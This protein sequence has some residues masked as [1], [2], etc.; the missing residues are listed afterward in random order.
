VE[1]YSN[2]QLMSQTRG[3]GT[4]QAATWTYT[5]DPVTLGVA[6]ITDPNGHSQHFTYDSAG[7]TL[8]DSDGLNHQQTFTY[9]TL[10]DLRTFTDRNNNTTIYS[11]NTRGNLT[12]ISRTLGSQTQTT[13]FD[14]ADPTYPGDVGSVSSSV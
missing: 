11:Y 8:S 13:T 3:V 2:G 14:H 7:N 4:P 12:S 10:N 9:D 1:S 6:T 5:Y